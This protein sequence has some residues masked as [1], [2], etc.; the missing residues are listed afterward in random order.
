MQVGLRTIFTIIVLWIA[1]EISSCRRKG[2]PAK[3]LLPSTFYAIASDR[4][5]QPCL[6]AGLTQE[7]FVLLL[8]R[9]CVICVASCTNSQF[10]CCPQWVIGCGAVRWCTSASGWHPGRPRGQMCLSWRPERVLQRLAV[11]GSATWHAKLSCFQ[12]K[13]RWKRS[14]LPWPLRG[15]VEGDRG[16][17]QASQES[18]YPLSGA[19]VT[20]E[21]RSK[22]K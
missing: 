14:P 3:K 7:L 22:F 11:V 8:A 9:I 12:T 15:S 21:S 4:L 2:I 18:Y 1:L 16:Y 5:F 6:F 13:S 10:S 19:I 17:S 20:R